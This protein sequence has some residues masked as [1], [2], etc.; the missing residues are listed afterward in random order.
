[1]KKILS[2]PDYIHEGKPL[3][4]MTTFAI[5]GPARW[6]AEPRTAGELGRCLAMAADLGVPV[7]VLGGGSNLLVADA[8]LDGMVVKLSRRAE[9]GAAAPVG[10][11]SPFWRVGAAVPLPSLVTA[12]VRA[13][14][15]G[16]EE[17]AGI[18]GSAGGAAAMNAG[19]P[20]ASFGDCVAEAEA[21]EFSGRRRRLERDELAFAYR[22]SAIRDM[23][24]T[25]LLLDLPE[26]GDPGE[27]MERMRECRERKRAGQPL[28]APSAGCVFRNPPG[29]SA[30]SL[31][32]GAGCKAMSEGG[33]GVSALHANFIVNHGGARC[34]D[35]AR[36]AARMRE[37]V[38]QKYGIVLRL[39]MKL[40]GD[41][42]AFGEFREGA[43][44][45][46]S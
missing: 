26:R 20:G 23:V 2:L 3:A 14:V 4:G 35:V 6:L 1:M 19:V 7:H 41:E 34:R 38:R 17:L 40:W 28:T 27:L 18:P 30:G 8:G 10:A 5:G 25:D 45:G 33:A 15:A 29:R 39:E 42:P 24:V 22:G 13:G 11:E 44:H 21:V 16:L 43:A 37:A 9:F 31:L 36:L 12:A 32:D 46:D